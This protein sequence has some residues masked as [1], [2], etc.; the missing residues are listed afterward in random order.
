V[1][2]Q[3]PVVVPASIIC[4]NTP[5]CRVAWCRCSLSVSVGLLDLLDER[6]LRPGEAATLVSDR[7]MADG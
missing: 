3:P 4:L 5:S 2:E 7:L 1:S 6:K